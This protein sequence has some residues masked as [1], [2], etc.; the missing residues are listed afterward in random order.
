MTNQ[1]STSPICQAVRTSRK[2]GFAVSTQ[3]VQGS[4]ST[5]RITLNT[6]RRVF[7]ICFLCSLLVPACAKAKPPLPGGFSEVKPD[8]ETQV[9][10]NFAV[11]EISKKLNQP[12]ALKGIVS[13][14]RQV[15]AGLNY[16][17]ELDLTKNNQPYRVRA[18]VWCRLDGT[19][20]LTSWNPI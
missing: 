16:R 18:I 8:E 19:M 7:W 15:V 2:G 10:A 1:N 6:A 11:G 20:E 14:E 12:L 4:R 5:D 3:S 9:A 17:L 13:A